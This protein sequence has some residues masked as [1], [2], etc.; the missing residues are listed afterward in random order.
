MLSRFKILYDTPIVVGSYIKYKE[1]IP[2]RVGFGEVIGVYGNGKNVRYEIINLNKRLK[3][4]VDANHNY[5]RRSIS[6][7]YCKHVDIKSTILQKQN[8]EVGDIVCQKRLGFKKYGVIVG[9]HHPDGILSDNYV[10]THNG[11]DLIDCVQIEPRCLM[12]LRDRHNNVISF[13]CKRSNLKLCEVDMW[14]EK[15]IIIK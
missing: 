7:K 6:S 5:K 12:R 10:N 3:C 8:F 13:T 1:Q 4:I 9:F 15:G 2:Q 14:N 11:I